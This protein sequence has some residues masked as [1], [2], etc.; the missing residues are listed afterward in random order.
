MTAERV[1]PLRRRRERL[2]TQ[3]KPR[4]SAILIVPEDPAPAW[5]FRL[6]DRATHLELALLRLAYGAELV[7]EDSRGMILKPRAGTPIPTRWHL[8]ETLNALNE[9]R[10]SNACH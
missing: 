4:M 10:T 9:R 2:A 8:E 5:S 7:G 6:N 1:A 3:Y